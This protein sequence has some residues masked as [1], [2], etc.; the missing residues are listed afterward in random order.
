MGWIIKDP[1]CPVMC[2]VAAK[3]DDQPTEV[4]LTF[5]EDRVRVFDTEEEAKQYRDAHVRAM[6]VVPK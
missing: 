5:R 2:C 6:V 4:V 1:G 3:R